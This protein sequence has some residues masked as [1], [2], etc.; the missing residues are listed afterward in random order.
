M[1]MIG[2]TEDQLFH[3]TPRTFH[4]TLKGRFEKEQAEQ[5]RREFEIHRLELA[6]M[7]PHMKKPDR[8]RAYNDLYKQVGE[9]PKK[10][11]KKMTPEEVKSFL[12]KHKK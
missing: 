7:S 10:K 5:K 2:L 9:T 3:M 4:N 12:E 1:G 8:D 11:A 6:M